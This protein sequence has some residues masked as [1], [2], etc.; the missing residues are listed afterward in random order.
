V[1]LGRYMFAFDSEQAGMRY[2]IYIHPGE[3]SQTVE[4]ICTGIVPT[5]DAPYTVINVVK[6]LPE[7]DYAVI[8]PYDGPS[9]HPA[10]QWPENRLPVF[11]KSL[12]LLDQ[13]VSAN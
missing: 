12:D 10:R 6:A 13:K 3:V 8:V 7:N 11:S 5:I 9:P 1:S 2:A 4:V